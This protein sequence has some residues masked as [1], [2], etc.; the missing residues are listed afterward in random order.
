MNGRDASDLSFYLSVYV[1]VHML[2][3]S[4]ILA[5]RWHENYWPWFLEGHYCNRKSIGCSSCACLCVCVCTYAAASV[6]CHSSNNV[7][8]C[9]MLNVS[10]DGVI[11]CSCWR[12][13]SL[14]RSSATSSDEGRLARHQHV[15]VPTCFHLS[16][17]PRQ[18]L[19]RLTCCLSSLERTQ[20]PDAV[21]CLVPGFLG[22]T[23]L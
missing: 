8:M 10:G 16:P 14:R 13:C 9:V 17:W 11:G 23:W 20:A 7:I 2:I 12:V 3:G 19:V 1:C 15:Q 21:Q 4:G 22:D 6:W 5:F 18:R